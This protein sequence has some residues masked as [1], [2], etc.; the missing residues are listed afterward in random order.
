MLIRAFHI[1]RTH[2]KTKLRM[3][4]L[5]LLTAIFLSRIIVKYLMRETENLNITKPRSSAG[6]HQFCKSLQVQFQV[7]PRQFYW[8]TT[9]HCYVSICR[10]TNK[11]TDQLLLWKFNPRSRKGFF[12][13]LVGISVFLRSDLLEFEDKKTAREH[14]DVKS[15]NKT[16]GAKVIWNKLRHKINGSSVTIKTRSCLTVKLVQEG[17]R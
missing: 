10:A 6:I 11:Q 8:V 7:A 4:S 2:D 17:L 14:D 9:I 5:A 12:F 15:K 3:T 16:F 13:F 1:P